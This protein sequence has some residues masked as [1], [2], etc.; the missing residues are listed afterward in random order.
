[1]AKVTIFLSGGQTIKYTGTVE[2][3]ELPDRI[4]YSFRP[5]R[6]FR[7]KFANPAAI[8]AVTEEDEWS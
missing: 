3:T 7:I 4:D 5:D 1:M 8:I 2:I 6:G